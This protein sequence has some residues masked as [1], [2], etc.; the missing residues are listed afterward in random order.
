[1]LHS[2]TLTTTPPSLPIDGLRYLLQEDRLFVE[3]LNAFLRLPTF[4]KPLRWNSATEC[5]EVVDGA[6]GAISQQIRQLLLEE[7]EPTELSR[8]VRDHCMG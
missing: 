1:M 8:A 4:P 3:F 6:R 5:F 7:R 2:T